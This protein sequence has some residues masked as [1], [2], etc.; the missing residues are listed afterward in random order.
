MVEKM[1]TI[2]SEAGLHARP[3]TALVSAVTPLKSEVALEYNGKQVNLK[4]IMGVMS[5]GV[6]KGATVK[7]IATGDD[8]EQVISK[9]DEVMIKE[10]LAV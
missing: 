2:T 6:S 9:I 7:V 4:S 8:E 1:Y 10:E 3:C 5:L